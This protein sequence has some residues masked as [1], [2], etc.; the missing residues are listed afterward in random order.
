M[1]RAVVRTGA[2]PG[3]RSWELAAQAEPLDQRAV[4]L[5]VGLAAGTAAGGGAGRRAAAGHDGCGGR[6]CAVLRCSVRSAMRWVSIAIWTSGEPVSPLVGPVLGDDLLLGGAVERHGA[7]SS[8]CCAA[9]RGRSTRALSLRGRSNGGLRLPAGRRRSEPSAV[10]RTL[11]PGL[12][13]RPDRSTSRRI[14]STSSSTESKRTIGRTRGTKSTA[15]CSP[16]RSRSSRSRTYASTRRSDP[17]ERRVG[18]DRDRRRQ[19]LPAGG[20]PASRRRRR[21][22]GRRRASSGSR[23]AVGKPS[24]RPRWSPCTTTP[25][26]RCGRPSTAAAP[27]TSPVGQHRADRGRWTT[28]ADRRRRPA[29]PPRP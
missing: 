20:G 24:S 19:A 8:V 10:S 7:P 4:A 17:V 3:C 12:E 15:T 2:A 1:R 18:A 5:D 21:R 9:L 25:S 14:C 6:A 16:Y 29:R 22:P 23:L 27:S 13:D 26:T 11:R 28:P